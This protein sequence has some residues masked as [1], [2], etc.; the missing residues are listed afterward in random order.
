MKEHS[1]FDLVAG[2]KSEK[3]RKALHKCC[4]N[5]TGHSAYRYPVTIFCFAR[6][7]EN[8]NP[9]RNIFDTYDEWAVKGQDYLCVEDA[10]KALQSRNRSYEN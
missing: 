7:C 10:L 9:V 4:G 6:L 3:K 2:K 1:S 5:C 8:E